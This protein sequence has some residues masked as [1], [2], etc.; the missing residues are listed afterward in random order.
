MSGNGR[1]ALVTGAS[2]QDRQR[3]SRWD[4][5]NAASDDLAERYRRAGR[6]LEETAARRAPMA[7]A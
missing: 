3:P 5:P 6:V 2:P 7:I 1:V 4:W